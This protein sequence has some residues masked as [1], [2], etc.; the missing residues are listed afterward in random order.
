VSEEEINTYIGGLREET[1]K[2][3]STKWL[4]KNPEYFSKKGSKLILSQKGERFLNS[5]TVN[6]STKLMNFNDFLNEEIDNNDF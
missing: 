5:K 2:E 6:E 4:S 3:G 1:G